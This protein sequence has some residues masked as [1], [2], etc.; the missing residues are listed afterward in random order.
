MLELGAQEKWPSKYCERKWEELHPGSTG[1]STNL[2]PPTVSSTPQL[3]SMCAISQEGWSH[4]EMTTDVEHGQST[5]R[6][7]APV[8]S[9]ASLMAPVTAGSPSQRSPGLVG[10]D[11]PPSDR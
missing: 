7:P 1:M 8:R 9:P 5:S 6:P 3:S 10:A 4:S 2:G 11:K